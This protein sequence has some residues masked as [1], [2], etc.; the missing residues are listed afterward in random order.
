MS[1]SQAEEALEGPEVNGTS[2]ECGWKSMAMDFSRVEGM[3]FGQG[4]NCAVQHVL[5][6]LRGNFGVSLSLKSSYGNEQ[7][8][9]VFQERC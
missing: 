6:M 1:K 4:L 9:T 3:I 2:L 8:Y 5:L 7:F